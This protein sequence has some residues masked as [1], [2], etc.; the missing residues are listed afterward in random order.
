MRATLFVLLF[1]A[2]CLAESFTAVPGSDG[3]LASRPVETKGGWSTIDVFRPLQPG[4]VRV[5]FNCEARTYVVAP[6]NKV[7]PVTAGTDEALLMTTACK[8]P[9]EFWK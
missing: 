8:K 1:P 4:T 3:K 7:A 5:A 9:W 2:L 6:D